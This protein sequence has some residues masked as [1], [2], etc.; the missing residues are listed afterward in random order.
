MMAN[1][2]AGQR[3]EKGNLDGEDV[4]LLDAVFKAI[5][6]DGWRDRMGRGRPHPETEQFAERF[7]G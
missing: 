1:A 5:G 2:R 3:T 7:H 4:F 6:R